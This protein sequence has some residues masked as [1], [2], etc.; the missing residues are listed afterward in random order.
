MSRND[1]VVVGKTLK[2]KE[3]AYR[4]SENEALYEIAFVGG[5]QLPKEL[6]GRWSDPR[7]IEN[8]IKV[9]LSKEVK[10]VPV[11]DEF[12]EAVKAAKKRPSK[13][14]AAKEK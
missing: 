3:V 11:K 9:Y 6:Q 7:Q 8:A 4:V 14:K 5:G 12:K 2:G 13:L 1:S 10:V